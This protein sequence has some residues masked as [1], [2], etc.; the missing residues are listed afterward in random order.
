LSPRAAVKKSIIFL[1]A[2]E[3]TASSLLGL[4]E[5]TIMANALAVVL[6]VAGFAKD[7]DINNSNNI[8]NCNVEQK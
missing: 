2:I 7:G 3:S 4:L 6:A 5:L 8:N 1:A